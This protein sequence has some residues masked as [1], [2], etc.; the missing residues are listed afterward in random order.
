M[1]I[2]TLKNNSSFRFYNTH[3]VPDIALCA[4]YVF[5]QHLQQGWW[6]YLQVWAQKSR[7]GVRLA[8]SH[9]AYRRRG[10]DF[11]LVWPIPSP[12]FRPSHSA[13]QCVTETVATNL[14]VGHTEL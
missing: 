7:E 6:G 8:P 3:S 1:G 11:N 10:Q 12:G 14:H 13:A 2:G 9:K 4:F 5:S